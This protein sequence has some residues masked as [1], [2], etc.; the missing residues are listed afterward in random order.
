MTPR[1][2]LEVTA[3]T[4]LLLGAPYVERLRANESLSAALTGIT[5]AVVGVIANL[6]LYFAINTLFERTHTIDDGPLRLLLPDLT[7]I[8]PVPM[9]ITV[10]AA[11]LIFRWK[12]SVLRVL[13][14][15]AALGLIAGLTDLPGV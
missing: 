10:L 6:G 7:S 4:F 8:R 13:G 5:A 9:V 1:G 15:S 3:V 2:H 11:V 14:V 12:W